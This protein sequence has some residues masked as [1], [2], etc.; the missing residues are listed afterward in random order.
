VTESQYKEAANKSSEN[1]TK[2]RFFGTT[3]KNYNFAFTKIKTRLNSGN[4]CYH[5]F[6]NLCLPV[7]YVNIGKELKYTEL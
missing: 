5:A 6:Q 4:A 2:F 7:C 3:A 1:V